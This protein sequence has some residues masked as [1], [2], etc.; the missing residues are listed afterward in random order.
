MLMNRAKTRLLNVKRCDGKLI[1]KVSRSERT[2]DTRDTCL[3][4]F[5]LLNL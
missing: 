2:T 3:L 1:E 5:I 4:R